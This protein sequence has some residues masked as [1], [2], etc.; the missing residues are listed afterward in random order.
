MKKRGTKD[1]TQFMVPIENA[2]NPNEPHE[3]FLGFDDENSDP[4]HHIEIEEA[5]DAAI[6]EVLSYYSLLQ[7]HN[8]L[9]FGI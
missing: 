5:Q 6:E 3:A 8:C 7:I 2:D 4:E 9:Q 1:A